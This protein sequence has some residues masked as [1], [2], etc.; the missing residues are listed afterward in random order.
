M[1]KNIFSGLEDF[2]FNHISNI[3]L[4]K[5]EIDQSNDTQEKTEKST[6]ENL[7]SLLYDS[8]VTC[9]VCENIFKARSI[10]TSAARVSS[11]DSDSFIRYSVIN[12]YFYDVWLCN[13]CGYA[14]M[15]ID[16]NRIR[17]YHK[18]AIRSKLTP[19]WHS[20]TYPEVYDVNIAIE[21]YK[22]SLLN[23][24]LMEAKSSKK[25][26][27]CL[28]LAWMHRLIGDEENELIFL[29]ESLEGF[30][31]AYYSEEFPIYGMNK[32]S[33]MY[34]I[35]ELNRR[36]GDTDNALI[37]FSRVISTAGASQKLKDLTRDQRD[38]IKK[39]QEN[40]KKTD[41]EILDSN[42]LDEDNNKK[43]SFFSK[44]FK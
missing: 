33:C 28:K 15:K 38:L 14:A 19:R 24:Y 25:A 37:W 40:V 12:P 1:S 21:R 17:E 20:K 43:R 9:P 7:K 22:L 4:Y 13:K 35:G 39:A 27:N 8:Q 10:K 3:N 36:V 44:L 5:K 26:M 18:E 29:T 11:K 23:Y 16:F 31:H 41:T 6:E 30:N 42:S 2:G 32:F 34:L